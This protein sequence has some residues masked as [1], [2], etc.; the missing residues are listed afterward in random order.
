MW[1]RI[2]LKKPMET[3]NIPKFQLWIPRIVTSIRAWVIKS[4]ISC[5]DLYMVKGGCE[6]QGWAYRH[7]VAA[8]CCHHRSEI[9]WGQSTLVPLPWVPSTSTVVPNTGHLLLWFCGNHHLRTCKKSSLNFS[10]WLSFIRTDV[11]KFRRQG[12]IQKQL[13]KLSPTDWNYSLSAEV[14]D[15]NIWTVLDLSVGNS[16]FSF[17]HQRRCTTTVS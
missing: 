12:T 5:P 15:D 9:Q 13:M 7:Q 10:A 4:P 1:W 11:S 2:R 6:E 3:A 14:T 17:S 8:C 16:S